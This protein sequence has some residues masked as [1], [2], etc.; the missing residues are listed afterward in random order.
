MK[1][2]LLNL[3]VILLFGNVSFGQRNF[4][5]IENLIKTESLTTYETLQAKY[6][7]KNTNTFGLKGNV[8][9]LKESF[10][11]NPNDII[12]YEFLANGILYYLQKGDTLQG[13]NYVGAEFNQFYFDENTNQLSKI[14]KHNY[15]SR[16]SSKTVIKLDT[17]NFVFQEIYE[18]YM[19]GPDYKRDGNIFDYTLNYY[20]NTTKDTVKLIYS[21]VLPSNRDDRHW[22]KTLSFT[23][24]TK[25]NKDS[26]F[27]P[28][29][30]GSIE[31]PE[32]FEYD[33]KGNLIKWTSLDLQPKST[34]NTDIF[35]E[36]EYN[37]DNEIIKIS[38]FSHSH[39]GPLEG[40]G[41][42]NEYHIQYLEY[43]DFGNWTRKKI[44]EISHG[45]EPNEHFYKR[46]ISYYK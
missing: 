14:V 34:Y 24:E 2:I 13:S 15:W 7:I 5:D 25:A 45:Q 12:R 33:K 22:N 36:Y 39:G 28:R 10:S 29:L 44:I 42:G 41:V 6:L 32:F 30:F 16:D 1:N 46:E 40:R 43:D 9:S 20:W 11:N 31:Y 17:N 19:C 23:N 8:K 27:A 21:Y 4:R 38:T 37:Q 18:C 26:T 3:I 35:I